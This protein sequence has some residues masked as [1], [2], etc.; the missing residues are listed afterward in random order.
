MPDKTP[1][2]NENVTGKTIARIQTDPTDQ[3]GQ[4][5]DWLLIHFTDGTALRVSGSSYEEV[6]LGY[7]FVDRDFVRTEARMAQGHRE[8]ERVVRLK[9]EEWSAL[10]NDERAERIRIRRSKMTPIQL[11]MEDLENQMLTEMREDLNHMNDLFLK[12]NTIAASA[13]PFT[14][15]QVE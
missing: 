8:K 2:D 3:F 4:D 1:S 6:S 5:S 11:M 12:A 9:R 15:G 14:W 13:Y 10:T 7:D